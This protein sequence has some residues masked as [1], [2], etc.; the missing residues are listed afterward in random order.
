MS[1]SSKEELN[2]LVNLIREHESLDELLKFL[3]TEN[4]LL[5]EKFMKKLK[6]ELEMNSD[7]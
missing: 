3:Q 5:E 1:V 6:S 2:E 7:K 4:I